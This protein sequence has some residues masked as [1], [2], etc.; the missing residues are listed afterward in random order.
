MVAVAALPFQFVLPV[1]SLWTCPYATQSSAK[2]TA[3]LRRRY[4]TRAMR[5]ERHGFD[6]PFAQRPDDDVT[7]L[8]GDGGVDDDGIAPGWVFSCICGKYGQSSY[9]ASLA[10]E[11]D[12]FECV[13]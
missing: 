7:G 13:R 11:G 8:D 4:A 1:S 6:I 10:P 5:L 9:P 3:S 2:W 12:Q